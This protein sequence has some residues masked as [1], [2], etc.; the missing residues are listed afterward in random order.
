MFILKYLH[1]F[2][3]SAADLSAS[4]VFSLCADGTGDIAGAGT[5]VFSSYNGSISI[6]IEA[7]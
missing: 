3:E 4:A 5:I 2:S 7:L 6:Q 1:M